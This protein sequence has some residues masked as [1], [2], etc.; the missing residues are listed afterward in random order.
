MLFDLAKC[1]LQEVVQYRAAT[2]ENT[3]FYVLVAVSSSL[4]DALQGTHYGR[5][6]FCKRLQK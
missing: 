3:H 6:T 2:F 1:Y 4:G 5:E